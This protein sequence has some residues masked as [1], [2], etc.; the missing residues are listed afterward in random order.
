MLPL[1]CSIADRKRLPPPRSL[2]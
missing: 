2:L 1:Q